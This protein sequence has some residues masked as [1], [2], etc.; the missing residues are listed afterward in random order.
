M[1]HRGNETLPIANDTDSNAKKSRCITAI[2]HQCA[3]DA[4]SI[5]D[6]E[7][8]WGFLSLGAGLAY[9]DDF[10]RADYVLLERRILGHGRIC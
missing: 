5:A 6:P 1:M 10:L 4:A 2:I 3:F 7:A 9:W 8:R